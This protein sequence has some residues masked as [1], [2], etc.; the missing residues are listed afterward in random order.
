MGRG[1]AGLLLGG[2]A[3]FSCA[4]LVA[5]TARICG[6]PGVPQ[7]LQR[8]FPVAFGTLYRRR[9]GSDAARSD[10]T[11]RTRMLGS[12]GAR[13]SACEN[14]N[15]LASELGERPPV[16]ELL[17]VQTPHNVSD[18]AG[19]VFRTVNGRGKTDAMDYDR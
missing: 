19:P 2:P 4:E 6:K 18:G 17:S 15:G 16:P 11:A 7:R 12:H 10:R 5:I 14:G 3:G 1:P 8:T 13:G 9:S